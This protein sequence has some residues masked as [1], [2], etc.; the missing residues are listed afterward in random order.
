MIWDF[1]LTKTETDVYKYNKLFD[2]FR[3]N[4]IIT[5]HYDSFL[6]FNSKSIKNVANDLN[7]LLYIYKE[8]F[9]NSDKKLFELFFFKQQNLFITDMKKPT[10]II[11]K[12]P[13]IIV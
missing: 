10:N 9:A 11:N 12:K 7:D 4:S 2:Y 8:L 6:S 5:D 1:G 13:Y 3:I